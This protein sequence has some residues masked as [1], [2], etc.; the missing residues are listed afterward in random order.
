MWPHPAG[1]M[2]WKLAAKWTGYFLPTVNQLH[3]WNRWGE[4][5][6]T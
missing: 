4:T 1:E 3:P 2:E 5:D 6:S